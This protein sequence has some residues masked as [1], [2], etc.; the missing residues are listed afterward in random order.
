MLNKHWVIY[1][2][3]WIKNKFK[4][5]LKAREDNIGTSCIEITLYKIMFDSET[6]SSYTTN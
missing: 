3:I 1:T 5:I 6:G 2:A 4:Q